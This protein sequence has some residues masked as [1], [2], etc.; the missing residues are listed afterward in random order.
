MIIGLAAGLGAAGRAVA[1]AVGENA[2]WRGRCG[3]RGAVGMS[4]E[5]QRGFTFFKAL[6]CAQQPLEGSLVPFY[7]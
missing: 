5:V 1:G 7:R 4:P 6:C 2:A 3:R